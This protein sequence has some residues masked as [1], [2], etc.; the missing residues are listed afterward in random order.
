MPLLERAIETLLRLDPDTRTRL[1]RLEGRIVRVRTT[2]PAFEITLAVV[3][4]RVDVLRVFD[5]EAD[6]SISGSIGAL[7]SLAQ[8]NDALY[9]GEVRIEGD[10]SV[11][12]GLRD[13]LVGVHV[14]PEEVLE[15]FLGGTLARR[16]GLAGQRLGAWLART[17][18]SARA[19][20]EEYLKEESELFA[21]PEEIAHWGESIDELRA[22]TDRLE[23][24][25]ARLE[26]QAA[27]PPESGT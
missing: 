21:P 4:G 3:E 24:R 20:A 11:A 9:S 12:Q 22:A 27:P 14:D 16:A 19:N 26:R 15:P 23:A 7:R 6:V 13:L 10:L 5:G 18:S 8:G 17:G 25:L 2:G 1:A